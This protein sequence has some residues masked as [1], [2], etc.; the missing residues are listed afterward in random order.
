MIGCGMKKSV[1]LETTISSY[2]A[3]RP[4]RDLI[5]AAHQAITREW[6]E[7]RRED[8]DLYVSQYVVD[9]AGDGDSEAAARRLRALEGIPVLETTAAV[10]SLG[11][12]LVRARVVARRA[13]IDALHLAVASVHGMDILLTWN[14]KHLA[15]AE[16]VPEILRVIRA[17]G[18]EPPIICTPEEL[19]GERP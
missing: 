15:N 5:L 10:V 17:H 12:A 6:W 7:R 2:L 16:R 13:A 9:E 18:H 3:S 1:Y 19:M 14:C 4:S 8:F 11:E